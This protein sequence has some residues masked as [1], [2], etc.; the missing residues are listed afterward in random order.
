ML[1]L[2]RTKS[3]L[4]LT[5]IYALASAVGI[6]VYIA[7]PFDMWLR[8]LISDVCATAF[9]FMFSL[10]LGNASVY[11]PYWSVA[12]VVILLALSFS[13]TLNYLKVMLLIAVLIW[14]VRLTVNFA[15]TFHNFEYQDWRYVMLKEKTGRLYPLVNFLGIHLFP[16]LVV[17]LCV[18]PAAFVLTSDSAGSPVSIPFAVLILLAVLL[19]GTADFQMH[20]FRKNRNANFIRW[21]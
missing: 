17:Y 12:P 6:F 19:Q 3:Y 14:G 2:N 10:A 21:G 20:R 9:V 1:K 18:L 13:V 5:F 4:L 8:L 11:D 7:L 15:Y 16:T